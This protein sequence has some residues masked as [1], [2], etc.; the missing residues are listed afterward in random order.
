MTFPDCIIECAKNTE[1]VREF[2][3]L[4]GCN[5]S[6]RGTPLDLAI[7]KA[8][9]RMERDIGVFCAFV[10]ECVWTRLPRRVPA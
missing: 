6:M 5:L 10:Y 1:F 4:M 2:D 9:G 8:T 3:R 7:D